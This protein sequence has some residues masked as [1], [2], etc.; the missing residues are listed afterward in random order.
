VG[1]WGWKEVPGPNFNPTI[2]K[3][4]SISVDSFHQLNEKKSCA[5]KMD[6]KTE[7]IILLCSRKTLQNQR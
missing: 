5:N 3:Y 2:T 7:I 1:A 6:M 4:L